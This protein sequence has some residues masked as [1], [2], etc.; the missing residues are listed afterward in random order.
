MQVAGGGQQW[1]K[2]KRCAGRFKWAASELT[3]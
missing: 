1:H 3:V 2:A